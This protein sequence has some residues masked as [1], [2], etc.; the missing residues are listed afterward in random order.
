MQG[1]STPT[2]EIAGAEAA[3]IDELNRLLDALPLAAPSPT[4]D[5]TAA[6]NLC[7]YLAEALAPTPGPGTTPNGLFG[8]SS[9]ALNGVDA[10]RA[11][12]ESP[13]LAPPALSVVIPVYNEE[14]NL[15][16]LYR[17]LTDTLRAT[18]PDYEIILVDDGS[19]DHS[20]DIL[21][22]LAA[23]DERLV[24]VELSRNFGHQVAIS[25]GLEHARGTGVAVM[26]AD[27]QDPPEV[28]PQFIAQWRAGH[29]VVY[30]VRQHRKEG[31]LKR[32]A[33]AGF[34]RLLQRVANIEIPL[35]S[36][37]FCIMDRRVVDL[38]VAM[39]ERSRFVRGIRSW[40]G[41]DQV[42]LAYER[43]ARYAG[44][45]KYTLR[46]L[47]YLALDGL[48]SFS[49]VPLR[50]ISLSGLAVSAMSI[51]L[52]LFYTI[53]KLT[54]GLTPPGFA[55][56]VVAI[57]FLAGMQLIT[58]G[59]IGEYVGRIFEEVKRR[60]LYVTRRV[61]KRAGCMRILMLNN[62]FP[63]LGG[64]TGTV[65]Q[66]LLHR[67]ARVPDLE[68]DLITSAL[69]REP[70][71]VAFAPRIRLYKVPVNNRN[72]HHSSNHELLA[73]A[74]RALPLAIER[75]HARNYDLCLAWS[76]M[77]AGALALVL[78]QLA[79]LRYVLRVCG[80]DI[81]G[82]ERRYTAMYGILTPLI[83]AAWHGA[84]TVVAKCAGEAGM[85]H[86]VDP[87]VRIT[88]IPNG[89]DLAAFHSQPAPE[90]P[91]RPGPLRLL[92]VGRLIE[93]KGQHHLIEAV[94][95]L[96]NAGL[97]V[98][99]ELVGTGD[100][101]AANQAL[102]ARLDV[103]GRVTFA[104]YV[105]REEIAARYAA[106]DVFVLPS[107]NEGMSVATLEA[108]GAGLPIVASRTG[109]TPE[110]IEEGVNGF[111]FDWADVDSLA[112]YLAMLAHYR[113]LVR[114]MGAA[115]PHRAG[116]FGWDAVAARYMSLFENLIPAARAGAASRG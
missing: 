32:A 6:L 67:L 89:V 101:L 70:E 99:L 83:R 110:L 4:T 62:E 30:A 112:G 55:T 114:R 26:D 47:I 14:D 28:L 43:H 109:G 36:G 81:P 8:A 45:P 29:D 23:H 66:A 105:P 106:A 50:I 10:T 97:D 90:V 77:P 9:A 91:G 65:N 37:D 88:L 35:D 115:S 64:G 44:E 86:A 49:Y 2:G 54:T 60:P 61:T 31:V 87:H 72:I 113:E 108:M 56:L 40:I 68:I 85:V 73:Y 15:P 19:R 13:R 93:R 74:P 22:A 25:A 5:A 41:F 48:I 57:F 95:R 11:A 71:E 53:K 24:I 79:G 20:G 92:C 63:P 82:F 116:R 96:T 111:T 58:I 69:G 94:R 46:R 100:A 17:R 39:P 27:L 107:Y 51:I 75:H 34:Y 33:Y 42:G 98:R 21:R 38:L 104:G 12:P 52:A 76:A 84:E 80:P 102:A 78:R 3:R 1:Q 18:E 59:V 7:R 103:A 16:A